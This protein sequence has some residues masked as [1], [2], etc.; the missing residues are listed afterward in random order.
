MTLSSAI[1]T[2]ALPPG[3]NEPMHLNQALELALGRVLHAAH[4]AVEGRP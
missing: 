3:W 2:A 1:I 4:Y